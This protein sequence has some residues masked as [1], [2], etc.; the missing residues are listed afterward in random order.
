M[1]LYQRN[2][3]NVFITNTLNAGGGD[4]M[5]KK[6]LANVLCVGVA[7]VMT[8]CFVFS[9]PLEGLYNNEARCTIVQDCSDIRVNCIGADNKRN[10]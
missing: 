7:C 3:Y 9:Q 1:F 5:A 6:F 10:D 2:N 8:V 4:N